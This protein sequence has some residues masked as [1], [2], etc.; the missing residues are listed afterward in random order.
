MLKSATKAYALTNQLEHKVFMQN[1]WIRS[2][3]LSG[4]F[5]QLYLK[6]H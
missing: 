1:S 5:S 6:R 2:T 3:I 4:E